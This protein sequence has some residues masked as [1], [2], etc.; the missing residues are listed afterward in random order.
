MSLSLKIILSF[1]V[2]ALLAI[3][4]SVSGWRSATE[5]DLALDEVSALFMPLGQNILELQFRLEQVRGQERTLVFPGLSLAERQ[6]QFNLHSQ[7]AQR[8]LAAIGRI[9]EMFE[10]NRGQGFTAPKTEAA[11]QEAKKTI[12]D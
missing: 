11:W 5:M 2:M 10:N 7:A 1:F 12:L 3:G 6:N 4:A 8:A 9:D